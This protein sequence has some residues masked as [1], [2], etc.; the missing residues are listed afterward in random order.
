L[1][2]DLIDKFKT[3]LLRITGAITSQSTSVMNEA[4]RNQFEESVRMKNLLMNDI[5]TLQQ[6]LDER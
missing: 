4:L 3:E 5:E 1:D 6:N 2:H